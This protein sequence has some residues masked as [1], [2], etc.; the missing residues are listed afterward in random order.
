MARILLGSPSTSISFSPKN[1][2]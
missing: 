2:N 1:K